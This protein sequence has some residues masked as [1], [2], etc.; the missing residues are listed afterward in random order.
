MAN[1]IQSLVSKPLIYKGLQLGCFA[2]KT[3][4]PA[5]LFDGYLNQADFQIF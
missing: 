1:A 5:S 4:F 3:R 2:R